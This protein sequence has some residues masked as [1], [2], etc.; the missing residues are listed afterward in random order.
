MPEL[1]LNHM[2]NEQKTLL[3]SIQILFQYNHQNFHNKKQQTH[4]PAVTPQPE[5]TD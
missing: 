5:Q 4:W 2:L 1:G 3:M